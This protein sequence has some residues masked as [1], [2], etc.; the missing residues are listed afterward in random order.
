MLFPLSNFLAAN[1]S[2]KIDIVKPD[3][4]ISVYSVSHCGLYPPLYSS[5]VT[6][7]L[8]DL[9]KSAYNPR[10]FP[11]LYVHGVYVPLHS[12]QVDVAKRGQ[13]DPS[14]FYWPNKPIAI[15]FTNYKLVKRLMNFKSGPDIYKYMFLGGY[16]GF[17]K[18]R[19]TQQ[20]LKSRCRNSLVIVWHLLPVFPF[21]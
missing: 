3:S 13:T 14:L 21:H 16:P 4:M 19:S 5:Q 12:M 17:S 9:G 2:P 11:L 1:L 15:Y 18:A 6:Q 20:I 7:T 8:R 10:Y